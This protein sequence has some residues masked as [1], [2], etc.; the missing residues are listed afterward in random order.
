MKTEVYITD[1]ITDTALSF[2]KR[3]KDRPFFCYVPYNAPHGP[4]QV[5]DRYFDKYKARGLD[6]KN[7]AIYGMVENIDDNL[8]RLL[9]EVEQ[10]N[11]AE[12]T[13]V[14]FL[15]DNGPNGRD[16]YNGGM[17]GAK[18]SVDE[19]GVRVPLFVRWPGQ[20]KSGAVISRIAAHI[21]LLPTLVDLCGLS[22]PDTKPIDGLSLTPL[23]SGRDDA[24]P[25]RMIF[26]HWGRVPDGRIERYPG[27]VRTQQYRLVHGRTGAWQLY[28]MESD[29]GQELD[30]A[31]A[32]PALADRLALAYERWFEEVTQG[33]V[34]R[35]PI[36]VGYPQA[37]VVILPAPEAYFAGGIRYANQGTAHDWLTGWESI[38]DAV[39]WDIDVVRAS[40][41]E[42]ILHYT[43][44]EG[45]T[46]AKI[47]ITAGNA[48]LDGAVDQAFRHTAV[49]RPDRSSAY[50]TRII[51]PFGRLNLG[52]L[53]LPAGRT[54][55]K[56]Q[57]LT[58]PGR[59]V[60]DLESVELRRIEG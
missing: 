4:F 1:V 6:D 26:S 41:Y 60:F 35:P 47:R 22:W 10:L 46:G 44:P 42:V 16:R 28:D 53:D 29:P 17:K 51:K 13:I 55:L 31:A 45:D 38:E 18:G 7:A 21:D 49:K 36:P 57:A 43:C 37:P 12:D 24:W 32:R 19:G 3:H 52:A 56:I 27:A 14:I 54:D 30:V 9:D 8:G 5:P 33:Y 25:D 39:W 40:R 50:A 58:K 2:I 34:D 48:T 11:L 20:I 15:T 23:L 59:L